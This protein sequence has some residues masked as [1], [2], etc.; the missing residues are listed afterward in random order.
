MLCTVISP[1]Y[2]IPSIM[3][4]YLIKLCLLELLLRYSC[5]YLRI[6]RTDIASFFIMDFLHS[7]SLLPLE[8]P[9]VLTWVHCYSFFS[10]MNYY[11]L[12]LV[13]FW[14]TPMTSSFFIQFL[15]L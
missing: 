14:L 6:F 2:L 15:P 8:F 7:N 11:Y 10:S 3:V 1:E 13:P 5:S 12:L 9:K 4:Y